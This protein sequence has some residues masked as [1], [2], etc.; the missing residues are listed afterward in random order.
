M[1]SNETPIIKHLND[2][3][4]GKII[5]FEGLDCSFKETNYKKIVNEL[6]RVK[7]QKGGIL[8]KASFPRYGNPY[9]KP[10][11]DFLSDNI[12]R[13]FIKEYPMA[14]KT[15][16]S[17]D[18]MAY[19]QNHEYC[20]DGNNFNK[21]DFLNKSCFVFDRY[22]L[23][24][25]IYNPMNKSSVEIEDIVFEK[26]YFGTPLPNIIIWMNMCDK[27]MLKDII[28]QKKVKDF[29]ELDINYIIDVWERSQDLFKNHM[30]YF[31]DIHI[32]VINIECLGCDEDGDTI[33]RSEVDIYNDIVDGINNAITPTRIGG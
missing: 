15:L 28:S 14:I 9:A 1:Q 17:I 20:I 13:N 22:T 11:N 21:F 16:F 8:F 30:A 12:R 6:E 23:S 26:K 19:W 2:F 10:S 29:N 32:N 24:N 7:L 31:K 27:Y 33:I 25:S 4:T 3:P 18:R 5:A